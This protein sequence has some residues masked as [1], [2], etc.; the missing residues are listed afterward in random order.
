MSLSVRLA[1]PPSS[2][3]VA[4]C[5]ATRKSRLLIFLGVLLLHGAGVMWLVKSHQGVRW[6]DRAGGEPLVFL[7][8]PKEVQRETPA[9]ASPAAPTP[10]PLRRKKPVI[11]PP[12]NNAITLPA[13]PSSEALPKIDWDQEAQQAASNALTELGKEYAYRNLAGLS[14][15]QLKFVRDNHLVPMTPGIVWAHPRVEVD[16]DTLIPIIHINDHCVLVLLIPFCVIGHIR[17]NDHLFD[18][19]HDKPDP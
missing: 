19:M 5:G 10:V 13:E 9:A 2:N 3:A 18:H 12:Q 7:P 8:L 14:P 16:P 17:P 6:R 4:G 15:E 1:Q 11:E